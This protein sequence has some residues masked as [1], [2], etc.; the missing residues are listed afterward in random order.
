[1]FADV[2]NFV[3]LRNKNCKHFLFTSS[4]ESAAHFLG[5]GNFAIPEDTYIG[6]TG[7][8]SEPVTTSDWPVW[9]DEVVIG[10]ESQVKS[11]PSSS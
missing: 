7:I 1:M 2:G 9:R 3:A 8:L 11:A 6:P 5:A 10:A 4:L